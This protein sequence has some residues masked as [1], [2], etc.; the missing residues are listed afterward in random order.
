MRV[1]SEM[2][3]K[4]LTGTGFMWT[5]YVQTCTY[6]YIGFVAPASNILRPF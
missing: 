6:A 1:I 4:Q 5:Q 3:T 2:L